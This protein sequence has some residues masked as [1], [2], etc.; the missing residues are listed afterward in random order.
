MVMSDLYTKYNA[1][2]GT[3]EFL[4]LRG[5]GENNHE[6]VAVC[7]W[8]FGHEQKTNFTHEQEASFKCE[9]EANFA[10]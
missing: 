1:A 5:G 6:L 7:Q 4:V 10:H 3:G 9:Q 8:I 2:L